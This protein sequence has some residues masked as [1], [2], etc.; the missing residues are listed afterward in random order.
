MRVGS[1]EG[2]VRTVA[3]VYVRDRIEVEF[4]KVEVSVMVWQLSCKIDVLF[5]SIRKVTRLC[6]VLVPKVKKY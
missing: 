5:I 4:T 3:E 2:V 6:T 1:K